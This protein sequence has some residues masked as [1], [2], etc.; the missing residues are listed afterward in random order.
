MAVRK[1]IGML[2]AAGSAATLLAYARYREEMRAVR[3]KVESGSTIAETSAGPV[4][5]AEA[6]EGRPLLMIHGAGGGYDQ[7]LLVARDF[8]DGFRVIA[9]SRF[10][11]LRTP[12]PPDP[13]PAAQA[14]AH[15]ALLDFLGI[16]KCVVAGVSAGGPSAIELAL[17]H[18][19]KVSAL[20]LLVPRTYDP[21]QTIGADESVQSKAVRRLIQSSADF[22]FWIAIRVARPAV[23]RFFGSLPELDAKASPEDRQ[24]VTE[25]IRSALPLS[26]RV[27]GIAVDS[28]IGLSPCPLERIKVPVLIVSA[29]DDLWRTLPGARFTSEHIASAELRVLESGGHLMIG[30][31]KQVTGWIRRFLAAHGIERRV[32]GGKQQAAERVLAEA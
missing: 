22:L 30:Q 32:R 28:G 4:E 13:S 14:D 31:E 26:G 8:A 6:G 27:R 25:V 15:A 16:A 1:M 23:V 5:Y 21:T 7:G 3:D 29:R 20:V 18:P 9:P 17:R 24:R 11:Y 2:S 19:D 10:G 12:V